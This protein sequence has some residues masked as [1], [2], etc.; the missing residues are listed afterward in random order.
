MGRYSC[1]IGPCNEKTYKKSEGV[2][3]FHLNSITAQH[4]DVVKRK[5]FTTRKDL[6]SV[7]QIK[8]AM[9]CSR[10]FPNGDKRK[11]PTIIPRLVGGKLVWPEEPT[12]RRP[13]VRGS[14][15]H[16]DQCPVSNCL[17]TPT[18]SRPSTSEGLTTAQKLHTL[19]L[20]ADQSP[21][22]VVRTYNYILTP[23]N[24]HS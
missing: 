6:K 3:F 19:N 12:K 10:H 15:P 17:S 20:L 4:R 16:T 13:P 14:P 7:T 23:I 9:I 2:K 22:K 5:I 21:E 8:D 1:A 11:M 24:C 18:S